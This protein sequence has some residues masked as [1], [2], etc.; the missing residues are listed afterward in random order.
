MMRDR[1]TMLPTC[2]SDVGGETRRSRIEGGGK[3]KLLDLFA[4]GQ[5]VADAE[6]SRESG[7]GE[8]GNWIGETGATC[9]DLWWSARRRRSSM[10]GWKAAD[11]DDVDVGACGC[12]RGACDADATWC[13]RVAN[14]VG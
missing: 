4:G 8:I 5:V 6:D 1:S 13:G 3:G 14:L 11:D 12:A 10:T 7:G 2:S 9:W